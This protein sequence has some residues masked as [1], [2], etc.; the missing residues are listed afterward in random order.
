[1]RMRLRPDGLM[2]RAFCVAACV[3]VLVAVAC[4]GAGAPAP[5]VPSTPTGPFE[6]IDLSRPW[7][8]AAPAEVGMDARSLELGASHAGR[9]PRFRSLLVARRGRLAFERYFVGTSVDTPFDVRSVTKSVVSALTGIAFRDHVLPGL[10]A[11]VAAYLDPPYR[12]HPD[13]AGLTVR[14]LLTMTS[15]YEWNDDVDYNPWVTSSDRVQFLLDRPRAAPPGA[16]F[17]YNSAAVHVLGVVL[18][19][20]SGLPLPQYASERLFGPLAAEG[21]AWEVL[22]SGTVNGGSGIDLRGRDLLKLGQLYLQRGFS[23]ERSVVPAD[24][25]SATTAPQFDWRSDYGAQ[26]RVT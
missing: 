15:G 9:I 3:E 4:G 1:M 22:D 26:R 19:K 5:G 2:P 6:P 13:D 11:P 24:W 8:L 10:D 7:T 21:V 14:H 23:A 20:A 18:Q 17:T 12:V 16:R 25:V